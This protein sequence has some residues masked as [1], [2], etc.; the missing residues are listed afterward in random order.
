MKIGECRLQIDELTIYDGRLG[1]AIVDWDWRLSTGIGDCRFELVTDD[2]IVNGA[3]ICRW[4][5]NREAIRI[6]NLQC[7]SQIAN[8]QSVNLQSAICS[9]Q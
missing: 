1:L 2:E 4:S 9:L 8:R 5:L 6:G 3:W 7:R